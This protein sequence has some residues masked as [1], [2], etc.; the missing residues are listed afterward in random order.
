[1][2]LQCQGRKNFC[3][4]IEVLV[5]LTVSYKNY[6]LDLGGPGLGHSAVYCDL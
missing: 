2:Y 1:M 6:E 4:S 3:S 5:V